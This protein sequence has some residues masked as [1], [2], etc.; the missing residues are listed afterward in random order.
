M[1]WNIVHYPSSKYFTNTITRGI[2]RAYHRILCTLTNPLCSLQVKFHIHYSSGKF[3]RTLYMSRVQIGE[4][5]KLLVIANGTTL[6][7]FDPWTYLKIR[8]EVSRSVGINVHDAQSTCTRSV[9]RHSCTRQL[10][11]PKVRLWL[12]TFEKVII[13]GIAQI[14]FIFS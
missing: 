3:T 6:Y 1:S 14:D 12:A 5:C 7:L 13:G 11:L 10:L 9:T 8:A 4:R 2:C